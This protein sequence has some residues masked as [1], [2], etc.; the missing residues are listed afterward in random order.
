MTRFVST[1]IYN[2]NVSKKKDVIKAHQLF[3]LPQD[4][5]VAKQKLPQSTKEQKEAFEAQIKRALN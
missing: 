1:M 3:A 5:V 2:T 4:K